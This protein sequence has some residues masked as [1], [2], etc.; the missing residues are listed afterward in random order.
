MTFLYGG[1][2]LFV[3]LGS[4]KVTREPTSSYSKDFL[5]GR[6]IDIKLVYDNISPGFF[7]VRKICS[8]TIK[9]IVPYVL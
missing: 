1:N 3:D 8:V 6:G 7:Y 4:G 5:G 2:I 9:K